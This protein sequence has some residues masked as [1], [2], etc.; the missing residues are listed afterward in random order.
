MA[1]DSFGSSLACQVCLG[2][3]NHLDFIAILNQRAARDDDRFSR[4][5]TFRNADQIPLRVPNLYRSLAHNAFPTLI[6]NNEY[7]ESI[8]MLRRP[9]HCAKGHDGGD[10]SE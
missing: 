7:R 9:H 10:Q 8:R 4:L 1:A 3:R 2:S 5:K 6:S